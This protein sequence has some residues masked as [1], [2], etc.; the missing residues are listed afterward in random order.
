MN[1]AESNVPDEFPLNT[2]GPVLGR[3]SPPPPQFDPTGPWENA[4]GVYTLIGT[5]RVGTLRL[6]RKVNAGG[7]VTLDVRYEK[8]LTEGRQ[9]VV[10]SMQLAGDG[11]LST[12]VAWT[13]QSQVF[14]AAGDPVPY[15]RLKKSAMAGSD[16]IEIRDPRQTRRLPVRGPYTLNWA[17]FDAVG[18]LPREKTEP[19]NFT[20]IDHFDQLKPNQTLS[21]RKTT[22]VTVA[23]NPLRLHAY[24]QI[25]EGIVPWVYW[26][27][28]QGRLLLAVSGLEGYVWEQ[29]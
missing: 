26:V 10:G 9:E 19:L 24:D 12:P 21:F 6:E 5:S 4:Y 20:L 3:F 2:M 22:T 15:T 8:G 17:L 1:N 7:R 16:A 28:N 11:P 23:G 25:G 29:S 14:D 18:R 13:F 27:D